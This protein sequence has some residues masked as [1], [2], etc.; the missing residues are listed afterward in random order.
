M[1]TQRAKDLFATFP[2][3]F[4]AAVAAGGRP[5]LSSKGT[6][7]VLDDTRIGFGTIRSPGTMSNVGQTACAEGNFID[8]WTRKGLRVC[9]P[10]LVAAKGGVDCAALIGLWKA[11]WDDLAGRIT[12]PDIITSYKS[13]FAEIYP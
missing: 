1:L 9:G 7:L 12:D 8:Q 10:E 2:S 13:K 5:S 11:K 6:F 4:V 3:D